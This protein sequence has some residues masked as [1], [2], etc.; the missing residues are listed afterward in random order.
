MCI[1]DRYAFLP[2]ANCGTTYFAIQFQGTNNK[3][4]GDYADG[5]QPTCNVGD[6]LTHALGDPAESV[7]AAALSYRANGVCPPTPMQKRSLTGAGAMQLVRPEV[8]EISIRDR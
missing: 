6:D 3:G 8:K 5:F 4:F 1:R 7:L 2:A